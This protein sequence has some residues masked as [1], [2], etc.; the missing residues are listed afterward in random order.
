MLPR[1]FS[2]KHWPF[3][4]YGLSFRGKSAFSPLTSG[5]A[6]LERFNFEMFCIHK[7]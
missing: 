1:I 5:R 7:K 4:P 3:Q 2:F 6:A